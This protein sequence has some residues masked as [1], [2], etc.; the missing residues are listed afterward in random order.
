MDYS[1]PGSSVHGIFQARVLEWGA[2]AFSAIPG[3]PTIKTW[4][5][6]R[7]GPPKHIVLKANGAFVHE[8]QTEKHFL[9]VCMD[10]LWLISQGTF[11]FFCVVQFSCSVL[12]DSL[13]PCG[14]QHARPPC[15]SPT[16]RVYSGSCPLSQ[17]CHP[18][19]SSSVVP[20]SSCPIFSST[21]VL[22][23]ESALRIR[24]PKYWSFS[25][26]ISTSIEH[27]RIDWLDLLAVQGTLS[28]KSSFFGTQLSL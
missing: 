6:V 17:W 13:Q 28:S 19:I 26:S 25:F 24:W 2:I 16:P 12:S 5:W 9:N 18:V 3:Y 22:S 4:T 7:H 20:F 27:S 14:L 10:S 8:T 23:N 11:K 15:P 21:S 1:L